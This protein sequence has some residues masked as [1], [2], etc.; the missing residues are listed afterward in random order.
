LGDRQAHAGGLRVDR[1]VVRKADDVIPAVALQKAGLDEGVED[2]LPAAGGDV[3]HVAAAVLLD[4]E[5][6]DLDRAGETREALR[7]RLVADSARDRPFL[8]VVAVLPAGP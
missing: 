4:P 7:H 3:V 2:Q 6:G 5:E 8:R 1:E